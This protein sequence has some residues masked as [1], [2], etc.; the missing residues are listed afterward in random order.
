MDRLACSAFT[1]P[2]TSTLTFISAIGC[3]LIGGVFFAFSTF[4]M[5]GLGRLP[6]TGA[7]PQ[8]RRST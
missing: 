6:A 4:V 2:M 1:G 5:Q 3:G 7:Q 8:C